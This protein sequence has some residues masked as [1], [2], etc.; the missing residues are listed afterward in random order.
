[1]PILE[2]KILPLGTRKTSVSP[3]IARAVAALSKEKGVKYQLTPMGTILEA[4]SV[5][6]LFKCAHKMHAAAFAP[7]VK[8]VVT[9][10]ELDDRRDKQLTMAGK[11]SSLKKRLRC[12]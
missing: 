5:A 9:F 11:I 6:K 7:G 4:A 10:L 12:T 2:I 1:M 8:R 3:H